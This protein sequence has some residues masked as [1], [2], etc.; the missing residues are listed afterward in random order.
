MKQYSV[1]DIA[2][3]LNVSKT[4]IQRIIKIKKISPIQRDRQKCYYSSA[5]T[6]TI[7]QTLNANY[8]ISNLL[9]DTATP[10]QETEPEPPQTAT[11]PQETEPE[12][13]HTATPPQETEP[14]PPQTTTPPQETEPEPPQTTTPPTNSGDEIL[15]LKEVIKTIQQQLEAKDKQI[16]NYEEQIKQKDKQIEDYSER[17]KEAIQLTRGQQYI[18]A[19]DKTTNLLN[20]SNQEEGKKQ[21]FFARIFK[22]TK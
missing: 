17:L 8:D 13:N 11:P 1:K 9:E 10:P 22:K 15:L 21:G 14:E 18:T 16:F 12:P 3:M 7:I 2:S 5:D 6:I 20:A 19:A 4:T